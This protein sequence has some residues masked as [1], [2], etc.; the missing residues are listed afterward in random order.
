MRTT[1]RNKTT[2]AAVC[3]A[4]L[5]TA[6]ICPAQT[7]N[8]KSA[9]EQPKYFHLEFVVKDL[10]GGKVINARHYSTTVMTGDRTCT[11]RSGNKVPIQAGGATGITY[12]DVGVNIDCHSAN[13][14]EGSLALNVTAEISSAATS[15]SQPMIRQTKWNSNVIVPIGKPTVIFSSDDVSTKGQT[16]LELTATPI[17]VR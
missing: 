6:G 4:I 11:I 16:Q 10:D 7:E 17:E 13:Q 9:P 15:S 12:V 14:I 3:G 1:I 5:L 8:A 2:L